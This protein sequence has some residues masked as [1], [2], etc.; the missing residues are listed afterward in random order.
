MDNLFARARRLPHP[1]PEGASRHRARG[2]C[3]HGHANTRIL[4]RGEA[5]HPRLAVSPCGPRRHLR[6]LALDVCSGSPP[7]QRRPA[8]RG[9]RAR[10]LALL[11][12]GLRPPGKGLP[13]R[14]VEDTTFIDKQSHTALSLATR[15]PSLARVL[16][17]CMEA[18]SR[19][20]HSTAVDT[21]AAEIFAASVTGAVLVSTTSVLAFVSFLALSGIRRSPF[22]MRQRSGSRRFGCQRRLIH[23]RALHT[24]HGA[25]VSCRSWSRARSFC[26]PQHRRQ[27]KPGIKHVESKATFRN[28][29]A[30]LSRA[31][32]LFRFTYASATPPLWH[33]QPRALTSAD[34][35]STRLSWGGE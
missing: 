27:A 30:R 3:T 12:G 31:S 23:Q 6:R 14:N 5:Q 11:H 16:C 18:V 15:S 25:F 26:S 32:L 17:M 1:H 29:M 35:V 7:A 13:V 8:P 22:L 20:Q 34:Q 33:T 28:Y 10:L 21:A 2:G 24:S 4:R 9:R 19:R